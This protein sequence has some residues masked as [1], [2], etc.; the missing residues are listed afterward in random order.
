MFLPIDVRSVAL[1]RITLGALLFAFDFRWAC[2][3]SEFFGSEGVGDS[4]GSLTWLLIF[5]TIPPLAVCVAVGLAARMTSVVSLVVVCMVQHS[6]RGILQ[7]GDQLLRV[8][9]VW[10]VLLP[11]DDHWSPDRRRGLSFVPGPISSRL[12]TA[13]YTAQIVCIYWFAASL[14]SGSEW[15]QSGDAL[16]F[17]LH[18]E[19]F[20]TPLGCVMA[21]YPAILRPMTFAALVLEILGPVLLLIPSKGNW[22]RGLAVVLF[23]GFHLIGMQTLLRIGLFPWACAIAWLPFIPVGAW[24]WL[25]GRLRNP[26]WLTLAAE[27]VPRKRRA[28][29]VTG[30]RPWAGYGAGGVAVFA[31]VD[32]LAWNVSSLPGATHIPFHPFGRILEQ[33]W[34]MYAPFPRRDHYRCLNGIAT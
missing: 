8:L 3:Y 20:T 16:A 11:I 30:W 21:K 23:L 15:R 26:G 14:K 17:A 24:D 27:P 4:G 19:H 29:P 10:C 34:D 6:A 9:L 32:M 22:L 25:V 31:S 12:I 1:F 7:G 18:I 33:R 28:K 13:C 5:W 2:D